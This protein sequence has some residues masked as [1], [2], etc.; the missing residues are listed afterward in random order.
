MG[1]KI[2]I[3]MI[4][5]TPEGA[6]TF[7]IGNWSGKAISCPRSNATNIL[8]RSEFNNYGVYILRS[9]AGSEDYDD[10][11][12]IG[13]AEQL[14]IRIKQHL[15]SDRDFDSFICFYSEDDMLTKAHVKYLESRLVTLAK[16][17]KSSEVVN[18]N[19]PTLSKLSEADISD[20]EYFIEQISLVLPVA[21][22][23]SLIRSVATQETKSKS[24]S[25]KLY[26]LKS[27]QVSARMVE[28][29]EGYLVKAGSQFS[30]EE[31]DSIATGW[32]KY[33]QN[34]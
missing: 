3:Y 11:I 30:L 8:K 18:S 27:K 17:A 29:S 24:D 10:A 22:I 12:Y 26:L 6:K 15:S 23:R 9:T 1:K 34:Y 13:E 21:G 19:S 25:G 16:E 5:G 4:D 28:V 20:M 32:K 33:E 2:T 31:T 7:E 14:G